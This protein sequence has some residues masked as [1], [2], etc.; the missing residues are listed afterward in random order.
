MLTPA[1][2]I[3]IQTPL[4]SKQKVHF[5]HEQRHVSIASFKKS[6]LL[7]D[8]TLSLYIYTH[9]H[10]H[11]YIYVY[12]CMCVCIYIIP[13]HKFL[14][15]NVHQSI[16]KVH[17]FNW[18]TIFWSTKNNYT[19][20]RKLCVI[21]AH[22]LLVS[23]FGYRNESTFHIFFTRITLIIQCCFFVCYIEIIIY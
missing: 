20:E 5:T 6:L 23:V 2:W 21:I 17:V 19:T 9:T 18:E 10:T 11:I 14:Y 12:I 1:T 8:K 7:H 22:F 16:S 4:Y 3:C 15:K 13:K